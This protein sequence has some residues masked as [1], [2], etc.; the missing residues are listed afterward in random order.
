ME[1][2][3]NVQLA[4]IAVLAVAVLAMSVGYAAFSTQ[5]NLNGTANVKASSWNVA[6]DEASL[7]NSG[8]TATT[9]TVDATTV[10]YSVTLEKPGDYYEADVNV[11]NTGTFD[12]NLTGITMS[13]LN[14]EQQKYLKYTVNYDGTEYTASTSNLAIAL[15]KQTG[16]AP[17]KVRVEYVQPTDAADLPAS[18]VEVSLTA[19]LAYEQA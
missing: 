13:S 16:T 14:T 10:S 17:V 3:K 19:T 1:K 8:V 7:T 18:D 12:A 4:V 2:G 6:F 9:Q 5:L 15:A 11:K